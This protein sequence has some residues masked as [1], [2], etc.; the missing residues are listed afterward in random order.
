MEEDNFENGL[1]VC[2]A[3]P[4]LTKSSGLDREFRLSQKGIGKSPPPPAG[5]GEGEEGE[6]PPS[7]PEHTEKQ[8][9]LGNVCIS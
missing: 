5:A 7:F 6:P 3:R 4:A 2:A 9:V 1:T 8:F